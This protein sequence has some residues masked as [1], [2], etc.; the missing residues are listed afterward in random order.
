MNWIT[1]ILSSLSQPFRW[2]IVV[3]PWEQAVRVRLGRKS[4]LLRRGIHLRIPFLD[5]VYVV[6]IRQRMVQGRCQTGTTKD[7]EVITVSCA[8]QYGIR[9]A[10]R[11]FET[12]ANPEATMMARV[13]AAISE[14]ISSVDRET[15]S[16]EQVQ[17]AAEAS[18]LGEDWGL[19]NISVRVTDLAFV[20]TYRLLQAH[21]HEEVGSLDRTLSSYDSPK[22]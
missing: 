12:V 4:D 1:Q 22:N 18:I 3:A 8:L 2:W 9:D 21:E 7:G 15:L 10:V 20:Q 13:R 11:L 14:K 19:E 16:R 17:K 5:R 6:A